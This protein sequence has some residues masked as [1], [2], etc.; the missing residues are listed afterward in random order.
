MPV[1]IDLCNTAC[2]QQPGSDTVRTII[3]VLSTKFVGYV[4]QDGV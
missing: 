4:L 3:S 2:K 1:A